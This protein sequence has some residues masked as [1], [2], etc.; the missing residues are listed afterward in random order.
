MII[1]M[2][3]LNLNDLGCTSGGID[4][5]SAVRMSIANPYEVV[6][7]ETGDV[8]AKCPD[9]MSAWEEAKRIGTSGELADRN[10]ISRFRGGLEV[11]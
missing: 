9:F 11:L 4:I 6:D 10:F 3:E 5:T 7:D 8:V 1:N 2:K